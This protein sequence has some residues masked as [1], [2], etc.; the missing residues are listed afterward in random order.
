MNIMGSMFPYRHAKQQVGSCPN[1]AFFDFL[2]RAQP[3]VLELM[4]N[5]IVEELFGLCLYTVIAESECEGHRIIEPVR[6][7]LAQ[8][9]ILLVATNPR[10]LADIAIE[11]VEMATCRISGEPQLV[12]QPTRSLDGAQRKCLKLERGQVCQ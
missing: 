3:S 7:R 8:R 10:R 1:A 5:D 9:A 4:V 11:I 12:L 2:L 6:G